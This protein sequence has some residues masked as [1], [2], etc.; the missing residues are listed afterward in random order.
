M[1]NLGLCRPDLIGHRDHIGCAGI[2]VAEH[3]PDK[4]HHVHHHQLAD[5]IGMARRQHHAH[6]PAHGMTDHCGFFQV[7]LADIAGDF[8]GHGG[9][10]GHRCLAVLGI[11]TGGATGKAVH[12]DAVDTVLALQGI[13][14]RLPDFR[15]GGQTGDQYQIGQAR[16]AIHAHLQTARFKSRVLVAMVGT[17]LDAR[18][19][20]LGNRR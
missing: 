12:M 15:R 16:F 5:Q 3:G 19:A 10:D 6:G 14:G 13:H 9:R 17:L 7:L 4:R 11:V 18:I 1:R 2:G 8:L 20:V